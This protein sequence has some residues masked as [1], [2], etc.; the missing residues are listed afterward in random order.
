MRFCFLIT[1]LIY[2]A[3][4]GWRDAEAGLPLRALNQQQDESQP[5]YKSIGL[6][7]SDSLHSQ[8]TRQADDACSERASGSFFKYGDCP[9]VCKAF[10]PATLALDFQA[11]AP[12]L[13]YGCTMQGCDDFL[14]GLGFSCKLDGDLV[15]SKPITVCPGDKVLFEEINIEEFHTLSYKIDLSAPPVKTDLYILAD[16]TGSMSGAISTAR[17]KA[18]DLTGV[19][20]DREHVAFAVGNYRD[21][22]DAAHSGPGY[23]SGFKHQLSFTEDKALAQEK[24]KEWSTSS[25][26]NGGDGPEANLVALYKI[27]TDSSIGWRKN[28]RKFV[29]YFGDISG[30]EPTCVE[31]LTID[32]QTVIDAMKKRGITVVAVNFRNI[33]QA[34]TSYPSSGCGGKTKSG[35]GQA[36]DI[37]TSTGGSIASSSD[38]RKLI[39]LIEVALNNVKRTYDVDSS[40]CD[41]QITHSHTPALP[42]ELLTGEKSTVE[43][44]IT[45]KDS[46][47]AA[48]SFAC[49]FK[50]TESGEYIKGGASFE[51]VKVTGCTE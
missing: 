24:I 27:A 30:H 7:Y 48:G 44:K 25:R 36:T 5:E 35:A 40:D 29:V 10:N 18:S 37:T 49:E 41:S 51:F 1:F 23:K 34:P 13:Q 46:I 20:G 9:N 14:P 33:D 2:F 50:Y 42:L 6:E 31:G 21:E 3:V 28:S 39:E 45:L 38:Q 26:Y 12:Y 32:R 16:T 8:S 47:C 43:N 22:N 19:F 4:S 17:N 15:A 11:C